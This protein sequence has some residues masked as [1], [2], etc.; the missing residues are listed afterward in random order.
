MGC[1]DCSMKLGSGMFDEAGQWHESKDGMASVIV[2]YFQKLFDSTSEVDTSV[3]LRMVSPKV[4]TEMN[5]GLLVPFSKDK[6]KTTLFQ[7]HPTK[8][9]RLD[10]M[11]PGFY[12]KHWAIVGHNICPCSYSPFFREYDAMHQINFTRHSYS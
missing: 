12:Q 2:N 3:V 1:M 11:T 10:G 5:Q 9:P 7:M 4:T 8:V 6:I